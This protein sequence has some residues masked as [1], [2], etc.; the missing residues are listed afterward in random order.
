[1][2][3]NEGDPF[4]RFL[5]AVFLVNGQYTNISHAAKLDV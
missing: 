5:S 3:D 4:L 1:M 2:C